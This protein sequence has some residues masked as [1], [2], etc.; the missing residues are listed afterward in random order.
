MAPRTTRLFGGAWTYGYTS[1]AVVF[2]LRTCPRCLALLFETKMESELVCLVRTSCHSKFENRY[3]LT[4]QDKYPHTAIL[5]YNCSTWFSYQEITDRLD[6]IHRKHLRR[7]I[8]IHC[9]KIISND[10]LFLTDTRNFKNSFVFKDK[11]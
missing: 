6:K 4:R 8:N 3:I 11:W 5:T 7:V 1:F 2:R 9:P 10:S